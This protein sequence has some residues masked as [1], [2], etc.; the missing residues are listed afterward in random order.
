MD[1]NEK[2]DVL[3]NR[4]LATV[5]SKSQMRPLR[6]KIHTSEFGSITASGHSH[7]AT[8]AP[9]SRGCVPTKRTARF[10]AQA[11]QAKEYDKK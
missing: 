8:T 6:T 5:A 7:S 9:A 4:P 11:E 3:L 1:A 2:P 10:E